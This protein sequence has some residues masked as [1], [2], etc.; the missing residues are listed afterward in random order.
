MIACGGQDAAISG[1][2]IGW[3]TRPD[4][5]ATSPEHSKPKR[6]LAGTDDSDA[7][8][9]STSAR[10]FDRGRHQRTTDAPPLARRRDEQQLPPLPA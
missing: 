6:R 9:I 10:A 7:L 8:T 4:D 2:R 1:F 3:Q 5:S